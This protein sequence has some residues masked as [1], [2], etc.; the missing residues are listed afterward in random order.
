MQKIARFS[1]RHNR[2]II[3]ETFLKVSKHLFYVEYKI[4]SYFFNGFDQNSIVW[5]NKV[6]QSYRGVSDEGT[7][8]QMEGSVSS[9]RYESGAMPSMHISEAQRRTQG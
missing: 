1:V 3:S 4:V 2:K 8:A 7:I 9:P 5:P 6:L